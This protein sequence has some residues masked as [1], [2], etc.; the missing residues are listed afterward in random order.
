MN[1]KD[2]IPTPR[3]LSS[4]L[5]SDSGVHEEDVNE[6]ARGRQFDRNQMNK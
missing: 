3:K 4:F 2:S 1:Y 6:R 5:I